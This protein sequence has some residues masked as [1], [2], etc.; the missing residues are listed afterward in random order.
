MRDSQSGND[1]QYPIQI[2]ISVQNQQ[3]Y[4]SA[5]QPEIY[6]CL[7]ILP[8]SIPVYQIWKNYPFANVNRVDTFLACQRVFHLNIPNHIQAPLQLSQQVSPSES[9]NL[10]AIFPDQEKQVNSLQSIKR[11]TD[12]T[13]EIASIVNEEFH[14][15][16][17]S[18]KE[19]QNF[20]N[21]FMN[22]NPPFRFNLG[23]GTFQRSLNDYLSIEITEDSNWRLNSQILLSSLKKLVIEFF[24]SENSTQLKKVLQI[25]RLRPLSI[26]L[27]FKKFY[28]SNFSFS[29]KHWKSCP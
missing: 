10:I 27:N 20:Q 8:L 4:Q 7:S 3:L 18:V 21:P 19:E 23:D 16:S 15:N 6:R 24:L 2:T 17:N 14:Q 1:P 26:I 5:S 11:G 25:H 28:S 29:K 22:R 13:I 12:S 9:N